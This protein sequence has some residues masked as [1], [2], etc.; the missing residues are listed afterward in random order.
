ML[1]FTHEKEGMMR[2]AYLMKSDPDIDICRGGVGYPDCDE[3]ELEI[4]HN[5]NC[6]AKMLALCVMMDEIEEFLLTNESKIGKMI[7]RQWHNET[8]RLQKSST[9]TI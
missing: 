4:G 2:N 9:E 8:D 7:L 3:Y 6:S 1:E 5:K